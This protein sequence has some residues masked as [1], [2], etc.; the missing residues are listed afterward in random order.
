MADIDKIINIDS[1]IQRL[2]EGEGAAGGLRR[3]AGRGIWGG[4]VGL[5]APIM[6]EPLRVCPRPGTAAGGRLP[7]FRAG[8][9]TC[10]PARSFIA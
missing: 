1:I 7:A 10:G 9:P 5:A 3:L 4:P 2:L 8:Y 6:S